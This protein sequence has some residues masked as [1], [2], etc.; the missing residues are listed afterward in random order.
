MINQKSKNQKIKICNL[1]QLFIDLI[2]RGK[3]SKTIKTIKE[4]D[5]FDSL[6]N[7]DD[8][9]TDRK[10]VDPP[11]HRLTDTH[12]SFLLKMCTPGLCVCRT[13]QKTD[14]SVEEVPVYCQRFFDVFLYVENPF[15]PWLLGSNI[16]FPAHRVRQMTNKT[17]ANLC[18]R[19]LKLWA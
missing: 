17:S 7:W 13:R 10:I 5:S 1:R 3:K 11:T 18:R 4:F 6:I 8:L 19:L 16:L 15:L 9:H 12:L 14:D 2:W